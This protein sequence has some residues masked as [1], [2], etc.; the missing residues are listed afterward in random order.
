MTA[1]MMMIMVKV[2]VMDI[3]VMIVIHMEEVIK[4]QDI[5][6]KPNV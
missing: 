3:Q 5:I 1:V 6:I 2:M 4:K